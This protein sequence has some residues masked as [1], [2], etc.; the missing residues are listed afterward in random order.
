MLSHR[1]SAWV[2]RWA[3]RL[4][5]RY[6][7][8]EYG[9]VPQPLTFSGT[10]ASFGVRFQG[11]KLA[12][13]VQGIQYGSAIDVYL[14]IGDFE[15]EHAALLERIRSSHAVKEAVSTRTFDELR[16]QLPAWWLF[17]QRLPGWRSRSAPQSGQLAQIRD[18]AAALRSCAG[19]LLSGDVSALPE[20]FGSFREHR[21]QE[22][23]A[24]PPDPSL[25]WTV[26]RLQEA[27]GALASL[28]AECRV[29]LKILA[30]GP[31]AGSLNRFVEGWRS[32]VKG[33]GTCTV[34]LGCGLEELS[35]IREGLRKTEEAAALV[36]APLAY[37]QTDHLLINKVTTIDHQSQELI[38]A[39][40]SL[41]H[42][43]RE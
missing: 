11:P 42:A 27:R 34:P 1:P 20:L 23:G 21:L 43:L 22:D 8:V 2:F 41:L 4:R 19:D 9:F 40:D 29:L 12:V 38:S 3:C 26:Q 35:R 18:Y 24:D 31:E 5:F 37:G 32:A 10:R 33:L 16:L 30:D 7:V 25:N 13:I 15:A 36:Q 17:D 28:H 39:L 14:E 6:L